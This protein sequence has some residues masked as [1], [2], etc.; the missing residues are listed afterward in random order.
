LGLGGRVWMLLLYKYFSFLY[1]NE[2]K[3]SSAAVL[4]KKETKLQRERVKESFIS[5]NKK[6]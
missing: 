1:L 2:M 5:K 3:G 4:R 6:G